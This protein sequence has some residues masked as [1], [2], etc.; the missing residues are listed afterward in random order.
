MKLDLIP[1][2]LGLDREHLPALAVR[3]EGTFGAVVRERSPWFDPEVCYDS[4][5]GQYNS[6][7]LLAELLD[8]PA[9]QADRMLAVAGVDLFVPVL[10]WVFGEAQLAGPAAV[11]STH[12]LHPEVYGLSAEPA[13]LLARIETEAVHELGHTYGLLH[14]VDPS[15]AMHA[16]TYAEEIDLKSSRFCVECAHVV[17]GRRQGAALLP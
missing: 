2:H 8:G 10:A 9:T 5:R 1:I 17:T 13:R 4:S 14:C 15:C 3:L 6:T 7:L 16:S 12:R 11:I